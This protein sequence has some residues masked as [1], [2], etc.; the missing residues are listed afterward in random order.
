MYCYTVFVL[1]RGKQIIAKISTSI[2]G[3][4]HCSIDNPE[5]ILDCLLDCL[6][7]QSLCPRGR[8][9]LWKSAARAEWLQW[10]PDFN[11]NGLKS[12]C[13]TIHM[14]HYHAKSLA[15]GI[16]KLSSGGGAIGSLPSQDIMIQRQLVLQSF[17][18]IN[19]D[20]S[21]L[22]CQVRCGWTRCWSYSALQNN[23]K[24]KMLTW[25]TSPLSWKSVPSMMYLKSHH[26]TDKNFN[27]QVKRTIFS[28]LL[29]LFS[30]FAKYI[31]IYTLIS[32]V[33]RES[34]LE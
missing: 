4:F 18:T 1:V 10:K 9:G 25:S 21:S 31:H 11:E 29:N 6:W 33:G 23:L 32:K 14:V 3:R 7:L 24:L 30:M 17:N 22:Y 27:N 15:V 8:N 34:L 2:V 19:N 13:L 26:K 12:H 16:V 28:P 20:D 5:D